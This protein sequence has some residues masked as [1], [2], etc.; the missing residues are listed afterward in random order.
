MVRAVATCAGHVGNN[1]FAQELY[2]PFTRISPKS[3]LLLPPTNVCVH[4]VTEF[5]K[6]RLVQAEDIRRMRFRMEDVLG[7][8]L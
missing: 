4:D 2:R 6:S 3:G 1:V 8:K 5:D 7:R